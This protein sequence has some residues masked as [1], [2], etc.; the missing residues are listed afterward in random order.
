MSVTFSIPGALRD[1]TG[2]RSRVDI[3]GSPATLADA[4]SLL[5]NL[6]PGIQDRVLTEQGEL[7]QHINIFIGEE[8]VRYTGGLASPVSPGAEISIV[9]A[10]SGGLSFSCS[11]RLEQYS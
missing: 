8:N 10:V 9:P 1:F 11:V 3:E 2:G 7:R 6:Y 5:W 4:L